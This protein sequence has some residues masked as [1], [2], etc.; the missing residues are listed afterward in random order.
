MTFSSLRRWAA[1]AAAILALAGCSHVTAKIEVGALNDEDT[2]HYLI[3]SDQLRWRRDL[4]EARISRGQGAGRIL[5][6]C[7]GVLPNGPRGGLSTVDAAIV[8]RLRNEPANEEIKLDIVSSWECLAHYTT[9]EGPVA[10]EASDNLADAGYD[11]GG[12]CGDWIGGAWDGRH[13]RDQ[14]YRIEVDDGVVE[15]GG[16]HGC[17]AYGRW[18]R[19]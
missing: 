18:I 15:L 12:R 2:G 11:P 6:I 1:G 7:V 14:E 9:D 4:E 8:E 17:A 10:A 5:K 13:G 19:T 3:L 16:G